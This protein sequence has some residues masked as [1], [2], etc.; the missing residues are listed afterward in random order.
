MN[1][2]CQIG[3]SKAGSFQF[4][5][6]LLIFCSPV[7]REFPASVEVDL[8]L[9]HPAGGFPAG[10]T[11]GGPDA[12]DVFSSDIDRLLPITLRCLNL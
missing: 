3:S 7:G 2:S 1:Y 11:H 9:D 10:I 8:I 6:M 12:P 4:C 5:K